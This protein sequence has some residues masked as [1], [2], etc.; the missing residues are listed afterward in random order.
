MRNQFGAGSKELSK[1]TDTVLSIHRRRFIIRERCS[2][3]VQQTVLDSK[4]TFLNRR[5]IAAALFTR[6]ACSGRVS[7]RD[8]Q[9]FTHE[10]MRTGANHADASAD[11]ARAKVGITRTQKQGGAFIYS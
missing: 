1:Y 9:F 10:R 4:N 7:G 6:N 5:I 8:T 2:N 3:C 11:A